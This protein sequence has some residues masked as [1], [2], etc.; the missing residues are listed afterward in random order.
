VSIFV[1]DFCGDMPL[2]EAH[3]AIICPGEF[4]DLRDYVTELNEFVDSVAFYTNPDYTGF[5]NPP[6]ASVQGYYYVRAFNE[7]DC[8]MDT[9]ILLE[10]KPVS[11][12]VI[13]G[14]R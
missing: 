8:Y 6:Y 14:R 7:Y 13:R 9:R 11:T 4:V 2:I 1:Y 12:P 3:D 10:V 5:M